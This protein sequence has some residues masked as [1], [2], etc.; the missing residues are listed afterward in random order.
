MSTD[1]TDELDVDEA[2]KRAAV[3]AAVAA[4]AGALAGAAKAYLGSRGHDDGEPEDR[5][6]E[7]DEEPRDDEAE[8]PESRQV[9]EPEDEDQTVEREEQEETDVEEPRAEAAQ[10]PEGRQVV[11][12]TDE[13]GA[14]REP[15]DAEEDADPNAD[16]RDA[17]DARSDVRDVVPRA[18]SQLIELLGR[19]AES[20]SGIVRANGHWSVTL[21]VV[22]VRRVPESTD[23]L[24]SYEVVLDDD[25]NVARLQRT[26]RYRRSQVEGDR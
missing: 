4:G 23:V 1:Q 16:L 24:A 6:Y 18:R 17:G 25:G 9:V 8:Q 5:S 7:R 19:D 10:E 21:E 22:E 12:P 3:A 20:V 2:L 26:H 13:T 15:P 11:E 14:E